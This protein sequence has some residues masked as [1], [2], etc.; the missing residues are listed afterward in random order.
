MASKKP[1]LFYSSRCNYSKTVLKQV[2]KHGI[3]DAFSYYAI[4]ANLNQIPKFV[5][6]VPTILLPDRRV[7]T[8]EDVW[9]Y[10]TQTA[11]TKRSAREKAATVQVMPVKAACDRFGSVY[12]TLE[13]APCDD[14]GDSGL[15]GISQLDDRP[16][17]T[18][19]A[20]ADPSKPL[21]EEQIMAGRGGVTG[22]GGDATMEIL[23]R[24]REASLAAVEYD[25]NSI[26]GGSLTG[27]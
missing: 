23:K 26:M 2:E 7:L 22:G 17:I 20:S 3:K 24:Q 14:Y 27:A 21:S 8:D 19:V 5:E 15:C 25:K 12:A 16:N 1:I 4:D 10:V 18:G 11:Q 6:S 9:A 13:G